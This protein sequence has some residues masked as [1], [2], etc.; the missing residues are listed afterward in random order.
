[1]SE[2][3]TA[4]IS[5]FLQYGVNIWSSFM[6][7]SEESY[8]VASIF[9]LKHLNQDVS[10]VYDLQFP[11]TRLSSHSILLSL[12]L[13][14]SLCGGSISVI[15]YRSTS[16]RI[17]SGVAEGSILSPTFFISFSFT[18]NNPVHSH[19]DDSTLHFN[20]SLTFTLFSL[21]P[22]TFRFHS[23]TI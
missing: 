18:N 12:A 14:L 21:A 19:A 13:S 4:L 2:L 8:I 7:N 3:L 16:F 9:L 17:N 1:M 20:T 11:L 23:T 6:R 5:P 10:S 22:S 15:A